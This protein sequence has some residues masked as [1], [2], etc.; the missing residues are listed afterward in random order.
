MTLEGARDLKHPM[1]K[2][3]KNC[4][5]DGIWYLVGCNGWRSLARAKISLLLISLV[6][7][8]I[9]CHKK[10]HGSD[11]L[12]AAVDVRASLTGEL[13]DGRLSEFNLE[14]MVWESWRTLFVLPCVLAFPA[15]GKQLERGQTFAPPLQLLRFATSRRVFIN[16][17]V[18]KFTR[19]CQQTREKP[20][21]RRCDAT[22][23]P[24]VVFLSWL[25]L[26]RKNAP[27][28][29]QSKIR[30]IEDDY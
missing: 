18:A 30:K 14:N 5:S 17:L 15:A 3:R 16:Q 7:G 4:W 20:K 10:L 24:K 1:K 6:A 27:T 25:P 8:N 9:G 28:F 29:F 23:P 13:R 26:F 11:V 21:A 12:L 19:V 22:R 2:K